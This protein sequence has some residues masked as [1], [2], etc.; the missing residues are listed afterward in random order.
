MAFDGETIAQPPI[1]GRRVLWWLFAVVIFFLYSFLAWR[2]PAGIFNSPD[3]TANYYF[4]GRVFEARTLKTFEPLEAIAQ[5]RVHPRAVSVAGSF[6]VPQSFHGLP[7]LYG[8]ISRPF[9]LFLAPFLTPLLAVLAVCAWSRIMAHISGENAGRYSAVILSIIPAWWYYANRG[10][11]HNILFTAC[12]IFGAFFL[13][14]KPFRFKRRIL[15]ATTNALA[16]G[17]C[18]GIALWVRTAEIMWVAAAI[19]LLAV[20]FRKK[21]TK[22]ELL[23]FFL[24]AAIGLAPALAINHQLYGHALSIGYAPPNQSAPALSESVTSYIILL[25]FPGPFR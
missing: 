21:I 10:L 18:V 8:L 19:V 23:M 4:A 2:Q 22:T 1:R 16:S 7:V 14:V 11:Y 5:G 3:E 6:L 20:M 25:N 24:G 9:G 13:V 12:L 15:L 17:L